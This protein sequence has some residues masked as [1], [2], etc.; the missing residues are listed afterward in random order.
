MP[1]THMVRVRIGLTRE[2][3]T[4]LASALTAAS[5]T[6]ETEY[7]DGSGDY[8]VSVLN[9]CAEHGATWAAG[10]LAGNEGHA[11]LLAAL[12][13][14]LATEDSDSGDCQWCSESVAE[15]SECINP[16]CPAVVANA[17]ITRVYSPQAR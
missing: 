16:A 7:L 12:N 3:A 13:G 14:L 2:G 5:Y 1:T 10:Y 11:D 17:A 4:R 9:I 8:T 6:A 15:Y